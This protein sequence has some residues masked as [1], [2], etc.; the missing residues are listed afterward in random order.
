M[1]AESAAYDQVAEAYHEAID[2]EGSGL[3]DPVFEDLVG[4]V[5]AY[6]R[7]NATN[8]LPA[9]SLVCSTRVASR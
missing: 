5:R 3:R 6:V 2:P 4:A 7:G 9:T 8:R 1:D